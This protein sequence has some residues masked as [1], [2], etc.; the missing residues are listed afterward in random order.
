MFLLCL[1][2]NFN[3]MSINVTCYVGKVMAELVFSTRLHT[4]QNSCKLSVFFDF[5]RNENLRQ[6]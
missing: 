1:L 3:L 2:K 6:I 5:T 4:M